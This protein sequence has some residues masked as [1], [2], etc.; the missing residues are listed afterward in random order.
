MQKGRVLKINSFGVADFFRKNYFLITVFLLL[1]IGIFI[2]VFTCE[3]FKALSQYANSFIADF[4]AERSGADFS[5]IL[6]GSFLES[7]AL[8]FMFFL[9][10]ASLFGVVTVPSLILVKGI[11][12]GGTTSYLY[13]TF[14]VKG[15]AFNA[16]ILI[17]STILILIVLLIS[18]RE[19]MIFSIKLSSLTLAKTLPFNLS[20]DF[21][22]YG[23]KYLVL[24]AFCFLGAVIDALVST[25]LLRHFNL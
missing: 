2:G 3:R 5:R 14:G 21:K 9:L 20:Q 18:A 19:S 4:I 1:V 16:V 22:N 25:G 7:F 11:L 8:L 12:L 24:A 10:G 23:I 6:I 13:S 15:V 17:P